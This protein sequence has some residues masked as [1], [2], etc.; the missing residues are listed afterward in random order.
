MNNKELKLLHNKVLEL[1]DYFDSF[2]RENKIVY[3]LM[4]GTALGA[5]RHLGFIPWDDDFDVFM[6]RENYLKFLVVAK[7]KLD[8]D[9][10]Y[11]QEENTKELPIY[12]S[13]IRMNNTTFIEK[14]VVGREMYHG[15]YIDVM[16]LNETSSFMFMRYLLYLSARVLSAKAFSERGYV[17]KSKLKQIILFITRYFIPSFFVKLLLNFVRSFNGKDTNL[18]GHFFGR[19]SFKRTSFR[20]LFLGKAR[21][22]KF[23]SLI[24]PVPEFVEEYLIVRY[25]KKYNELPSEKEKMKYPSHAFIVDT[26]KSY[27]E[28]MNIDLNC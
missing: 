23:N 11:F 9:K 10:Y 13:K 22:I 19:T 1:A 4:G 24:L 17:T 16:C 3:Y 5:V 20:K 26:T 25:G 15:V 7:Y 14:D 6:D 27:K 18:V 8:T 28:Y 12:F 21:Y 2:C